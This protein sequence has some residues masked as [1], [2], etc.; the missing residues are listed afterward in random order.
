MPVTG[1]SE[2]CYDDGV[3]P[4]TRVNIP[5]EGYAGGRY[6]RPEPKVDFIRRR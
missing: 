3:L 6:F 4:A 2:F 5:R 1:F